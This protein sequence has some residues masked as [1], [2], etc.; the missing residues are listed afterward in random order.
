MFQERLYM[1]S[2]VMM[3]PVYEGRVTSQLIEAFKSDPHKPSTKII[4]ELIAKKVIKD[5]REPMIAIV[6]VV[7]N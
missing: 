7:D 3:L 6:K 1:I 5:T 2:G 4:S